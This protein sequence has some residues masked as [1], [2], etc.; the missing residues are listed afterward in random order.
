MITTSGFRLSNLPRYTPVDPNLV[1]FQPT[2][3]TEGAL[4][5]LRLASNLQKYQSDR[6]KQEE[7]KALQQQRMEAA[8]AA[9]GAQAALGRKTM[10]LAP[11]EAETALA[12]FK[13]ADELRQ[14]KADLE[15]SLIGS[16]SK[17]LAFNEAIRG[18]V[19]TA[20]KVEAETAAATAGMSAANK[21]MQLQQQAEQLRDAIANSPEDNK[22][23][24]EL[25]QA[26]KDLKTALA[27]QYKATAA[28]SKEKIDVEREKIKAKQEAANSVRELAKDAR[29]AAAAASSA[30]SRRGAMQVEDPQKPGGALVPLASLQGRIFEQDKAGNWVPKK[31][32]F[33]DKAIP[34]P[35]T[36][37]QQLKAYQQ[38]M[39]R[40]KRLLEEADDLDL[41]AYDARKS[42]QS[43]EPSSAKKDE[44]STGG[45]VKITSKEQFDKL[46][47]GTEFVGPDGKQ[48]RKP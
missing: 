10:A 29:S 25:Q 30:V 41:Q 9:Y 48:Y 13:V 7:E 22:L 19:E 14:P 38:L 42:A 1:A 27:D 12:D 11:R 15:R 32:F 47:S 33:G 8:R 37:M 35:P 17:D 26:E 24:R 2:K 44:A 40:E 36:I 28:A 34:I 6:Q 18:E 20:K 3:L 16:R 21:V 39:D 23:K 46:P 4:D 43:N 31:E 5:A 45:V